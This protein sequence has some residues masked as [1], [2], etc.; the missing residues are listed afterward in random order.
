MKK[1]TAEHIGDPNK[2]FAFV[3][4]FPQRISKLITSIANYTYKGARFLRIVP[5]LI[6]STMYLFINSIVQ[7][8]MIVK[9]S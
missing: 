4:F 8:I 6:E 1:S 5:E 7:Y 3:N 9:Q 2:N